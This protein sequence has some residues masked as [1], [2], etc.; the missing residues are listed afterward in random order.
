[1]RQN[2]RIDSAEVRRLA[3][4]GMSAAP[5]GKALGFFRTSIVK[6]ARR[7]GIILPAAPPAEFWATNIELA[8]KLHADGLS[9]AAIGAVIG[10]TKNAVIGRFNR[11]GLS[12]PTAV[13]I[14]DS[15][16]WVQNDALLLEL[17]AAGWSHAKL[18]QKFGKSKGTIGRRLNRLEKRASEKRKKERR[19]FAR[20]TFP[21]P[22]F[23]MF[24]TDHA[25]KDPNFAFCGE[26]VRHGSAYCPKHH[27]AAFL[28]ARKP[29]AI[30][31]A[32]AR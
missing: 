27:S 12:T 18:G 7:A 23:C 22:G 16:F 28:P 15:L 29:E 21:D 14:N 10:C 6:A 26:P 13:G 5:I 11:M 20:I 31:D 24:P 17:R 32:V 9:A 30:S 8:L 25:P 4:A 3:E 19:L 1:M 2:R